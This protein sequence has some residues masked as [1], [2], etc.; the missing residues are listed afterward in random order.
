MVPRSAVDSG[1]GENCLAVPEVA[2]ESHG[3]DEDCFHSACQEH[4]A[5]IPETFPPADNVAEERDAQ[6]GDLL[7]SNNKET[8]DA[9]NRYSSNVDDQVLLYDDCF[10]EAT[11]A[12]QNEDVE[13][14]G[15]DLDA[16]SEQSAAGSSRA[17]SK[18]SQT[19]RSEGETSDGS[20][21]EGTTEA[22]KWELTECYRHMPNEKAK[23]HDNSFPVNPSDD[24]SET[25]HDD[26]SSFEF[27]SG[28]PR[29]I[30]I[31]NLVPMC[32]SLNETRRSTKPILARLLRPLF[33]K[34]KALLDENDQ[35]CYQ[36]TL[37]TL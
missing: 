20:P 30:Y 23:C 37:V 21:G 8:E 35:E 6:T 34:K 9:S 11:V 3:S 29:V 25:V 28:I 4:V 5:A 10:L 13:N 15:L 19:K 31:R 2:R 26:D 33:A 12:A 22:T 16:E 1:L 14:D 27:E 18:I 36:Q 32:E 7:E 17:S 24:P